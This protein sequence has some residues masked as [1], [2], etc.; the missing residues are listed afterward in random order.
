MAW[1]NPVSIK[2]PAEFTHG[3]LLV[4]C[5]LNILLLGV[6]FVQV[7]MYYNEYKGDR[8]WLKILIAFIMFLDVVNSATLS[9]FLYRSLIIFFGNN[10]A[11]T[12]GEWMLG[13]GAWTTA[14]IASAVQSVFAWRI[15]LLT[16]KWIY[17]AIIWFLAITGTAAG[18][19]T[20]VQTGIPLPFSELRD[21]E[22]TVTAWLASEVA[23]DIIITS[24][25]HK[26]KTGLERSDM[27]IDRIIRATLQTGLLTMIVASLDL[28]FFLFDSTGT[29]FMFTFLP[30]LYANSLLSSLNSRSGWKFG[31]ISHAGVG[32]NQ[33]IT[34][35][36]VERQLRVSVLPSQVEALG[37]ASRIRF[38]LQE[39]R[40]EVEVVET[41]R[42]RPHPMLQV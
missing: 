4:G 26:H 33:G 23:A 1:A 16:K 30:K 39:P 35:S 42:G 6:T 7:Y 21:T 13:T 37:E 14:V 20:A 25:L 10:E 36:W 12:I 2:G 24:V 34:T 29:H 22:A 19:A 8:P 32:T 38:E 9:A 40:R 15:Y 41:V 11:L 31:G 28:F 18:I 17:L 3:W 27:V 5:T